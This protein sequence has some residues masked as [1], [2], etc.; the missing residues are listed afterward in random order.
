MTK[1]IGIQ[2]LFLTLMITGTNFA[3]SDVP[4]SQKPEVQHL[5]EFIE[6][7]DCIFERNGKKYDAVDAADHI[8]KKYRYFR[9]KISTTEEFIEYSG[10]KSTMSGK[11]Y[12]IYCGDKDPITSQTWLL[13]E[14]SVYRQNK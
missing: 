4:E 6:T 5:L 3:Y 13:E 1:Y 11:P 7:S 10:T 14:L 2:I 9:N 12:R 8:K